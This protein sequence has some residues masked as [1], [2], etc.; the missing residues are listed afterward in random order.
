MGEIL[1]GGGGEAV[2]G[3]GVDVPYTEA[4]SFRIGELL[5]KEERELGVLG[6]WL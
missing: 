5:V 3:L 4:L 2:S 1:W 6:I